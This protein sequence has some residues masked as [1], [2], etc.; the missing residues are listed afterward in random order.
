[1]EILD[2]VIERLKN[3]EETFLQLGYSKD[4][5]TI[6]RLVEKE[7]ARQLKEGTRI[8]VRPLFYDCPYCPD[9]E[10]NPEQFFLHL[11]KKHLS[12]EDEARKQIDEQQNA[13]QTEL[14]ALEDLINKYTEVMLDV[15][16]TDTIRDT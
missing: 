16:Y 1:M 6:R 5:F 7:K 10:Q 13:Y 11:V 15:D 9:R 4:I 3:K 8:K 12:P 14:S 2:E